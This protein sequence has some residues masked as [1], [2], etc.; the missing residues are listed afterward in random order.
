M[1]TMLLFLAIVLFPSLFHAQIQFTDIAASAGVADPGNGQG[2]VFL[3]FD[4]DG[5]LDIHL[6]KNGQTNR[7]Y[8]NNGNLTFTDVAA[9]FGLNNTGA[10]RGC[11]AA[12]FNNDGRTDIVVGNFNQS[13]ILYRNDS[14][15]FTNVTAQAGMNVTSWGGSINWLDYNNDGRLDCYV[16]NNGIPPHYNYLFRNDNLASFSHV[17]ASLGLTDSVSTLSVATADFDNDGDTDIFAGNQTGFP[18]GY[19]YRNDGTTFTDVTSS[20]GL[21][22]S[23]YT[24]GAD[25]GDFDND[26]DLDLYLANSNGA[27][28]LFQN[29]GNGTFTEVASVFGLADAAQSFSCGW[30]DVDNDGDLD[31][32]VANS[33]SAPDRLYR[34]DGTTFTDV[35]AASGMVDN[36]L[37]NSTTW[38]DI[39]NDGRIDL[40]LSNNGVA[41]KLFLNTSDTTNRW[42]VLKLQGTTSNRSAIGAR[43]QIYIGSLS[44][45]REVQGGSGHNGQNSLA[46]EFGVGTA[47]VVDSVIIRWPS[48]TIRRLTTVPV[49]QIV[50]VTEAGPSSV[51]LLSEAQPEHFELMQNYP[52]PFNPKTEIR[53]QTSE[54]SYVTLKVYDL[55]GREVATLVRDE[56]QPGSYQVVFDVR[57]L[58]SGVYFYRLQAGRYSE[59]KRMVMTK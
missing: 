21:I 45:I 23:L 30:A 25:W 55:L 29:N 20:S 37:S 44:Q 52:N 2:V 40:Y 26:G 38:G 1:K 5:L 6:V 11:A 56:L 54:V 49:N 18:T 47:I 27:N 46:V 16:G 36:L 33:A 22:T 59:T 39:N 13:M 34:N 8:R 28:Q 12:D 32:Y 15:T 48:G 43:V 42:L 9:A 4:N 17:A 57:Q 51:R 24:W 3:D 31:L 53:Y 50:T 14:T 7:L 41:N 58:A 10:G 35:A 19:L